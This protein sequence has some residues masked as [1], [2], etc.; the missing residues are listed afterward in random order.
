MAN[1]AKEVKTLVD[2]AVECGLPKDEATFYYA[3][4]KVYTDESAAMINGVSGIFGSLMNAIQKDKE[5]NNEEKSE[6]EVE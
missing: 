3:V 5:M 1:K 6:V 2:I 4:G